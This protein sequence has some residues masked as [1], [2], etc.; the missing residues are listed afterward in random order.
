MIDVPWPVI[1]IMIM[2]TGVLIGVLVIWRNWRTENQ[3][4]HPRTS[5]QKKLLEKWQHIVSSQEYISCWHLY[6]QTLSI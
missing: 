2:V 4:F 6:L 1:S 3:A 5:E